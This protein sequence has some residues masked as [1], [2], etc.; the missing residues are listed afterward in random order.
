MDLVS[1]KKDIE[2]SKIKKEKKEPQESFI[3]AVQENIKEV[4]KVEEKKKKEE[5][6]ITPRIISFNVEYE[7]QGQ[8]KNCKLTSKIMD[9]EGRTKYDRYIAA[10]SSGFV[11]DSLPIEVQNRYAALARI[12]A[13]CI[14]APDWLINACAE[15]LDFSFNLTLKL[16][17]HEKR[18]FRLNS[19]DSS[20]TAQ[21]PRFSINTDSFGD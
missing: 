19:L 7:L 10:M 11:F 9:A 5:F 3:K 21:K 14:D 2:Q 12:M 15:D 8:I 13:Q 20:E 16:L 4:E 17:E 6:K 18:F 1:I